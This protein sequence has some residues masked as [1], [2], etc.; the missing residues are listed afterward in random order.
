MGLAKEEDRFADRLDRTRV[1]F[2]PQLRA[3]GLGIDEIRQQRLDELYQSLERI[4]D[5][6]AHPESFGTL[7]LKASLTLLVSN[8]AQLEV[9]VLPVLL[10]RK[11]LILER[12]SE[13]RSE[14]KID[15]L[16]DLV[17]QVADEHL[18]AVLEKEVV[19]L[20]STREYQAQAE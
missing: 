9:G 8:E 7:K 6:I 5:A 15:N 13:L 19:E 20:E 1:F 17:A 12:I 10:E 11:R 2:E 18:K 4:N 14:Q 16:R 3:L